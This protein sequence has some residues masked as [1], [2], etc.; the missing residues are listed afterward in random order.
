MAMAESRLA[1]HFNRDGYKVLSAD[2]KPTNGEFIAL[3]A[4]KVSAKKSA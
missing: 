1:A 4:D 2:D 3:I